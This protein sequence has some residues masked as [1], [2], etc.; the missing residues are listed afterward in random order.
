MNSDILRYMTEDEKRKLLTILEAVEK[1][2][3]VAIKN[4][5]HVLIPDNKCS[6]EGENSKIPC[7]CIKCG[8]I[9]SVPYKKVEKSAFDIVQKYFKGEK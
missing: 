2:R 8:N 5:D 1:R 7:I 4:C 3:T 9:I 6:I